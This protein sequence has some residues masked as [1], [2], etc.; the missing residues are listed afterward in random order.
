M[1]FY[2]QKLFSTYPTFGTS[3]TT[4][5][6]FMALSN[7]LAQNKQIFLIYD[8]IFMIYREYFEWE[9]Q[10]HTKRTRPVS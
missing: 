5:P 2:C 6:A 8:I 7:S 1:Y 3:H 4:L 9:V 10:N